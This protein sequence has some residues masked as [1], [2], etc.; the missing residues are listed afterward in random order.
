MSADF[1]LDDDLIYLNHAGVGP[2]PQATREAICAFAAENA[3]RGAA[4][5]PAWMLVEQ[6]LRQRLAELINAPS[7]NDIALV[8]STSEGLSFVA[9]GLDWRAGDN[10]VGIAEEFPS[11]RW[12]W[13]S[14]AS[15]GVQ[16]RKA[17]G[18]T[19]KDPIE[20][21]MELV[22]R[23][24][25][26][27]AVSSVQYASGLRLDL[28]RLGA[29]CKSAGVLFCVDAIQTLGAMRFDVQRIQA[30]FVSADGHKW[31]LAPEGLGLFYCRESLR[32]RITV[33]E[34]G[35]HSAQDLGNFD[36]EHWQPADSARR[37]EC[38]SPNMLGIHA[39]DASLGVLFGHGIEAVERDVIARARHLIEGIQHTPGLRLISPAEPEQH[40]GIVTFATET[41]P[42]K[43][44]Q[45]EL[46][47]SGV[48]CAPRGGGIR[49]SPHFHTPFEALDEALERVRILSRATS[50]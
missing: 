35:W 30:D 29:A 48:I 15:R 43:E 10:V 3:R 38:G 26:L 39:L 46:M 5:Y 47:Q 41:R 2:W 21:L 42:A 16:F 12:V 14:L 24:T 17:S 7:P 40:A 27:V 45:Q 28:E 32:D 9:S 34:V 18:L 4:D 11:N 44:V 31:L 23:N 20:A 13:D 33:N 1:S 8:K 6:R 37:F 36:L 25:R 19:T 22:D 49:F 50:R